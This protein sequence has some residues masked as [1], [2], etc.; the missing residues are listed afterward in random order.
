[1]LGIRKGVDVH[2]DTCPTVV[3]AHFQYCYVHVSYM[4]LVHLYVILVYCILTVLH[5]HSHTT[6]N[7]ITTVQLVETTYQVFKL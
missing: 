4:T 1:M 7:V 6:V 5:D 2:A 3:I